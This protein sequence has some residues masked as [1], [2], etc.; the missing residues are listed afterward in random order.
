M[1]LISAVL[2]EEIRDRA[3]RL[4]VAQLIEKPVDAARLRAIALAALELPAQR[5]TP[6]GPSG[7]P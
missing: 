7:R 1:I 5:N 3:A 2:S 4:G 6:P